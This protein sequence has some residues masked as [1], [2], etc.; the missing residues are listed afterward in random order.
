M[1]RERFVVL[2]L[3]HVRSTWFR[4]VGRWSTN[5][6]APIDFVKCVSGEELRAILDGGR[7]VSAVLV[8]SG[9]P[10]LDRDFVDRAR[11]IGAGIIVVDDGR[12]RRNW[13][14]LGIEAVLPADFGRDDLLGA[15]EAHSTPISGVDHVLLDDAPA[16]D[17]WRGHLVAVTG[18]GGV[19][20]STIAMAIAHGIAHDPR[21]RGLVALA[22]LALDADQAMLHD[23]GDVAPGLQEL[24]EAHRSGTPPMHD[25]HDF[26]FEVERRGYSLLVGLRQHR[27]WT[28]I[29][30][31][32][33]AA[34]LFNMQRAFRFVIADIDADIEGEDE[35]GS[36]DVEERNNIARHTAIH[37]DVVV[38]VGSSSMQGLRALVRATS[39]LRGLG[40]DAARMV[41]VINRAPRN[42]RLRA[43]ISRTVAELVNE[44]ALA[45]PIFVG[46][47]KRIDHSL[48]DG[49]PLPDAL[50]TPIARAV[51][52]T[53]E[54]TPR[55]RGLE[56]G[57]TI[58][59]PGTFGKWTTDSGPAEGLSA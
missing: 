57:P 55:N 36:L 20:T 50:C 18:A 41:V 6:S 46:E 29:R 22:D 21:N 15:L 9:L 56:D 24:V 33:F 8:D 11:T 35:T 7:A 58:V 59:R 27:D 48:R 17:V 5:A 37:A 13:Q 14:E 12:V 51:S 3:A 40:V 47:R 19:G 52:H 23:A 54:H 42:P 39:D 26:L 32:A 1:A 2:G 53:L 25:V 28:V 38:I 34:A 16:G 44:P 10:A 49:S 4:E 30:P 43:E 31:R 45:N